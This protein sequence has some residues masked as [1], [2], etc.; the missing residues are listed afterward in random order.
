MAIDTHLD[1]GRF[2]Q[3]IRQLQRRQLLYSSQ[4]EEFG[5]R[6]HHDRLR[7]HNQSIHLLAEID[8]DYR[9]EKRLNEY[10]DLEVVGKT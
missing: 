1:C 2:Q 4:I 3:R 8:T 5:V 10:K 9:I 7:C 6:I